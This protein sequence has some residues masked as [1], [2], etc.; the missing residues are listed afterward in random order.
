MAHILTPLELLLK[1]KKINDTLSSHL[2]YA[3]QEVPEINELLNTYDYEYSPEIK[4]VIKKCSNILHGQN[5]RE[6]NLLQ[7]ELDATIYSICQHEFIED[8]IDIT[9]DIS[10]KIKYCVYCELNE[11]EYCNQLEKKFN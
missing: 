2:K 6:I 1:L 7:I 8:Y 3:N 11:N 5:I 9:P 4:N 10:K